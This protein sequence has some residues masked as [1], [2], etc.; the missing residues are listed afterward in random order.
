MASARTVTQASAALVARRWRFAFL[1][2]ALV[3]VALIIIPFTLPT[4]VDV[5]WVVAGGIAVMFIMF[6]LPWVLAPLTIV[7][8]RTTWQDG[9]DLVVHTLFGVRRVDLSK[10]D[11][12]WARKVWGQEIDTVVVGVSGAGIPRVWLNWQTDYLV[13][14]P[15][16]LADPVRAAAARP[17]VVVSP[18]GRAVL[19][20]PDAPT[21]SELFALRARSALL[22]IAYFGAI[23]AIIFGYTLL[24]IGIPLN[25]PWGS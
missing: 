13:S 17:E 14:D 23:V 7:P 1:A 16:R 24:A 20:L 10:I 2:G 25:I 21:G 22:F 18:R 3:C 9:D 19:R 12:V 6:S 4:P 5:G 11:H 15:H 8:T